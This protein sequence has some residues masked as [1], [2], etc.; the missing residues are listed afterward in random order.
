MYVEAVLP[1][2][3]WGFLI[4]CLNI[5]ITSHQDK[6]TN[7]PFFSFALTAPQV[8][9]A[10]FFRTLYV[11]GPWVRSSPIYNLL[12]VITASSVERSFVFILFL[13]GNDVILYYSGF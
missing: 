11:A 6:K 13:G 2:L 8:Y 1:I 7:P 10:T 3:Y 12:Q 5:D 9:I 4:F